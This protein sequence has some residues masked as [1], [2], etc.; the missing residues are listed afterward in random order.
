MSNPLNKLTV[1][2][3]CSV[4]DAMKKMDLSAEKVLF[5]TSGCD[6]L[7]GSLTDGDIRR[8]ILKD[9]SLQESIERCYNKNPVGVVSEGGDIRSK[10]KELMLRHKIEA[11]P[12]LNKQKILIDVL[13][14]SELFDEGIRAQS[15]VDCPV[16][17]MAG[18]KG[19][20]LEPF[21]KVLPK[22]LIPIGDK[23][24]LEMLLEKFGAHGVTDFYLTLNYRGDVIKSYLD[25]TQT[26]YNLHYIWEDK[27]LGTAGSLRLLPDDLPKKVIVSN[28]DVI[29][30]L[31]YADLLKFHDK[32]ENDLTIVGSFQHHVVSYGVI[33]FMTDGAVKKITEKP[34]YD[35]TINTGVYVMNTSII[36]RIP[37]DTRY[38]LTDLTDLLLKEGRRVGVYPV[39][40]KS[41]MDVG[42]WAEYR[43]NV[44]K[45]LMMGI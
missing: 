17:I 5:V 8:F 4:K 30:D 34:E 42:Q 20:R 3:D 14:W 2:V 25:A 39:S 1:P 28:C 44:D 15:V 10:A 36:N 9:G 19:E 37:G 33:E 27:Y 32:H 29:V 21:T 23:P 45:I 11:I 13:I 35:F 6:Q 38:H 12:V 26:K 18:G 7:V 40:E 22:P 24:I 16:V 41:Y 31:D 43:K